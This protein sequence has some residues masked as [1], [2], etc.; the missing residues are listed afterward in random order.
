MDTLEKVAAWV[1]SYPLWGSTELAIDNTAPNPG[2]CGLF[3]LGEEELSRQE[4][5]LGNQRIRYRRTFALRRVAQRGEVAARW[6]LA[7]GRWARTATPPALGEKTVA[8]ATRGR[9]LTSVATG[10]ATY[11]ITIS[12]EY[13]ED[14][15]EN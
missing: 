9:L 12:L 7:F 11:D 14:Y 3:P 10:I 5:V 8:K 13:T 15:H 6:M 4:D 1:K 2:S